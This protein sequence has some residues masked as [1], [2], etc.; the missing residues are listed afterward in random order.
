MNSANNA[1]NSNSSSRST[2]R[3][4]TSW[5]WKTRASVSTRTVLIGRLRHSPRT[6][7]P[8]TGLKSNPEPRQSRSAGSAD[9]VDQQFGTGERSAGFDD[10]AHHVMTAGLRLRDLVPFDLHE[11][12]WPSRRGSP[13][14]GSAQNSGTWFD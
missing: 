7:L 6:G 10:A 1:R 5:R 13:P 3:P 11:R 12:L 14:P 2:P 4:S 9:P 8:P